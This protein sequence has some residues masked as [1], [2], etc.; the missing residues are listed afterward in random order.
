MAPTEQPAINLI[1]HPFHAPDKPTVSLIV[2][3]HTRWELLGCISARLRGWQELF[4]HQETLAQQVEELQL[5]V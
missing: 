1:A 3:G 2:I 5:A 4:F